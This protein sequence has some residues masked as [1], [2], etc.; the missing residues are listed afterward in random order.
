M[1]VGTPDRIRAEPSSGATTQCRPG[2]RQKISCSRVSMTTEHLR[3]ARLVKQYLPEIR[4]VVRNH[5]V[6]DLACGSGRNGLFLA[7]HNIP[8]CFADIDPSALEKIAAR[9]GAS[10]LTARLWQVD[11]EDPGSRPLAGK[12]FDAILV[13][14]YLHR[15]LMPFIRDCLVEGGL[16]LYETFTVA[17]ANVGRPRNP[18]FLLQP[19]ELRQWFRD[20]EI[21]L[22]VEGSE[23]SPPRHYA[24]LVARKPA[25]Q[26]RDS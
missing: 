12:K 11:F 19:A 7:R 18:A 9:L 21:L 10:D 6:L 15:P 2:C 1:F 13:C 5:G 8:I 26:G 24:S 20:W 25:G 14:N 4:A 3:P 17:Q 16:L 22:D 23:T